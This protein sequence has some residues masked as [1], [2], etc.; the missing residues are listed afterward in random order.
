MAHVDL[1]TGTLIVRGKGNKTALAYARG[2]ARDVLRAW[3]MRRGPEPGAFL[4]PV[5]QRGQVVYRRSPGGLAAEVPARLSEHAVYLR[6]RTRAREAGVRP[7]S[8]HDFR[9]T[10]AG[11]L[12]DAGADIATVQQLLRHASVVTT[13]K[14]DRRGERAKRDAADLL[15]FPHARF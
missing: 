7:F 11:D 12:L 8:P 6:L 10:F 13:A 14:Y 3:A 9:R 5:T 4:L 2:A 1:E 15:H